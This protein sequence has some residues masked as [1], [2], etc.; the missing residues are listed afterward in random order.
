M[1]A[2]A[3]NWSLAKCPCPSW[4]VGTDESALQTS[5][6]SLDDCNSS[7]HWWLGFWTI[8]V[9]LGVVLE[10]VFV[11]WEYL[12]ELH[13]FR[14][15]IMHAPES[16]QTVLFVL[17]L[18]GAGLVAAGVSGEFWKEFQIATVETCIRKGNDA[19]FLLLSKEAGDAKDSAA[20][21]MASEEALE[22]KA[23]ALA[24]RMKAASRQLSP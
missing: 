6:A 15:G 16:P 12:D 3:I 24:T 23:G 18:F 7:L 10:A 19:L 17:G 11:I 20:S 5:L 22:K 8:L 21:A 14:R 9:A 4:S 13:D 1:I 2:I